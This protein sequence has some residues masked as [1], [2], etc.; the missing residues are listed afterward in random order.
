MTTTPTT[1]PRIVVGV[2]GSPA[3][4]V[5]LRWALRLG[6]AEGAEVDAVAAWQFPVAAAPIGSAYVLTPHQDAEKVLTQTVDDVCGAHRPVG[7]TLRTFRGRASDVLLDASRGALMLVVGS[8]G[9]AGM[10]GLVLG[11]VSQR[12]AE[13]ATCPVLVVHADTP[14]G[15]PPSAEE[16]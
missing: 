15:E 1:R 10:R 7:L 16:S 2:D 13:L 6:S 3:S 12:V 9:H 8:R 14:A 4:H 11:S 5:A